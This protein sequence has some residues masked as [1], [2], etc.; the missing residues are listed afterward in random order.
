MVWRFYVWGNTA[1]GQ[2]AQAVNW[3]AIGWEHGDHYE[4]WAMR[5]YPGTAF[6]EMRATPEYQN[7]IGRT[8]GHPPTCP[9]Y[10]ALN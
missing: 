9:G 6:D 3:M 8:I 5:S 7:L 10:T 2:Y 4:F 1:I